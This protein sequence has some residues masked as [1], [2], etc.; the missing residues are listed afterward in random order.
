MGVDRG[1]FIGII[2]GFSAGLIGSLVG[3]GGGAVMVP[4][5]VRFA[6]LTRHS[7]HGTS[8]MALVVTGAVGAAAYYW[9][10]NAIDVWA[11]LLLA[12]PAMITARA[13]A[14]FAGKTPE[15]RLRRWFGFLLVAVT[16]LILAKP[17]FPPALVFPGAG[18]KAAVL[19]ST[20]AFTGFLAGLMGVG[21]GS[22]MV[23]AMVLLA[24]MG[25]H[26]A[27]GSS[28]LAMVPAAVAG[29]AEHWRLGNVDRRL[30]WRILP[31]IAAGAAMG[32]LLAG[33][34]SEAA[35]RFGFA[36]FTSYVAFRYLR[37]APPSA[38]G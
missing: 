11:A 5:L 9:G 36:L 24:G 32:G 10:N 38:R 21:G 34:F 33:M 18:G 29:S 1:A 7:A 8:L 19:V 26:V 22:I 27:Q 13:G 28:L 30:V 35:L 4:L 20:G 14:R 17:Y 23:P 3:L 31:G 15:W 25:Q 12:L 16:G 2:I 6:G 37:A